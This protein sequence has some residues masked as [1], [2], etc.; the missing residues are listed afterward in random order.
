MRLF[1]NGQLRSS[2]RFQ[3]TISVSGGALFVGIHTLKNQAMFRGTMDELRIYNRALSD[4]EIA[5]LSGE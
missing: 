3:G 2:A 5:S 4:A 1:Q